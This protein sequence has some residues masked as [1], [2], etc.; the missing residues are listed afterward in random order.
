MGKKKVTALHVATLSLI[1]RK[2]LSR[3]LLIIGFKFSW[4]LLRKQY[5]TN[6]LVHS[7]LST[8][9]RRIPCAAGGRPTRGLPRQRA[10]IHPR[11]R[12]RASV[13]RRWEKSLVTITDHPWSV[14]LHLDALKV[15]IERSDAST[16]AK[17]VVW[18]CAALNSPTVRIRRRSSTCR[19]MPS[20]RLRFSSKTLKRWVIQC[21]T[22]IP[23][24]IS[25]KFILSAQVK[26]SWEL[27]D[28]EKLDTAQKAKERGTMFFSAGKLS[29]ALA[30][31]AQIV[32]L[33][34]Y[35]HPANEEEEFKQKFQEMLIA[36]LLNWYRFLTA[37]KKVSLLIRRIN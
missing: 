17:S 15:S 4:L 16:R 20:L 33:L 36:G 2:F 11:R 32:T 27:S 12:R 18:S 1:M 5:Y 26:A 22:S 9:H 31:Y 7:L 29:L 3:L 28:A 30:K 8:H 6:K 34:E 19:P 25:P 24:T 37:S 23:I 14:F 13:A 10:Q 21:E 35:A